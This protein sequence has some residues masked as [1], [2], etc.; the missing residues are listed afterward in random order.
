MIRFVLASC[1]TEQQDGNKKNSRNS[2]FK[3]RLSLIEIMGIMESGI[4]NISA[5]PSKLKIWRYLFNSSWLGEKQ[6]WNASWV[7]N[8]YYF[9]KKVE[10]VE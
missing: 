5:E 6:R 8:K 1:D 2:A 7:I 10:I 4:Y 3:A 9:D